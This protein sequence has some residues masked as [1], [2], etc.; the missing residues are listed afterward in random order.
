MVVYMLFP[1]VIISSH[2]GF[3]GKLLFI[4]GIWITYYFPGGVFFN[5]SQEANYR[6][7]HQYVIYNIQVIK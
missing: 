6:S 1:D 7:M 2:S 3:A 4:I 5:P